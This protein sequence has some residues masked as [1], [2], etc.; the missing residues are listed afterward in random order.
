MIIGLVPVFIVTVVFILNFVYCEITACDSDSKQ[1][2]IFIALNHFSAQSQK[3]KRRQEVSVGFSVKPVEHAGRRSVCVGAL[4][5]FQSLLHAASNVHSFTLANHTLF[6]LLV[7]PSTTA[8]FLPMSGL[9]VD[10]LWLYPL[11]RQ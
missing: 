11:H 3:H 2:L 9:E 7:F 6:P 5:V 1:S 10:L 8:A 4:L